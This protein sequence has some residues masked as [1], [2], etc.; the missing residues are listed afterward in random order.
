M[1]TGG[2][3]FRA[4]HVGSLIRPEPLR[5]ARDSWMAGELPLAAL[6]AVENAC[7]RE[8]IAMQEAVGLQ[9]ITDGEFR[10]VSWRDGFFENIAGFSPEREE[11]DFEFRLSG[12]ERRRAA[13]VPRV[14]GRLERSRG[15]ATREFAF[16]RAGDRTHAEGDPSCAL[17]D[18]L[19]P[20]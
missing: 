11:S 2:P 5:R 17:R 18:A 16:L 1:K 13:P 4:E 6:Q 19:F 8:A 15:I 20:G 14:T 12:G 7:I 10:R 9:S 3:P